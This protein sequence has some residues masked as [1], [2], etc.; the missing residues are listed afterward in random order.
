MLNERKLIISN[1]CRILSSMQLCSPP[2]TE[3]LLEEC[4]ADLFRSSLFLCL[5]CRELTGMD[6][7][8]RAPSNFG[9]FNVPPPGHPQPPRSYFSGRGAP[10]PRLPAPMSGSGSAQ[11][12]LPPQDEEVWKLIDQTV[13]YIAK[14]G[15][16]SEEETRRINYGDPRFQFLFGNEHT[17]YYRFRL[18]NAVRN[19]HGPA[20]FN[21][22]PSFTPRSPPP[23][24]RLIPP[25]LFSVEAGKAQIEKLRKHVADSHANLLAQYNS[26]QTNREEKINAAVKKAERD[27]TYAVI[28]KV[29]LDIEPLNQLLNKFEDACSKDIIQSCKTWIFENCDSDQLREV[30]LSFLLFRVKE[31]EATDTFKLHI[32]YLINDWAIFAQRKRLDNIRQCLSRY[33]SQMYAF[34]ALNKDEKPSSLTDKLEKLLAV[35]DK[36]KTFDDNTLKQVKNPSQVKANYKL[37]LYSEIQKA[38]REVTARVYAEYGTYEQQ[39]NEFQKH[40][41]A[42]IAALEKQIADF[43]ANGPAPGSNN[44]DAA[45]AVN[46][47]GE[48][49]RRTRFDQKTV[50]PPGGTA[51]SRWNAMTPQPTSG[52]FNRLPVATEMT[53]GFFNKPP[54]LSVRP[55]VP[56]AAPMPLKD[57]ILPHS[58]NHSPGPASSGFSNGLGSAHQRDENVQAKRKKYYYECGAGDMLPAVPDD[59]LL[60]NALD[61]DVLYD[62][63]GMPP[64]AEILRELDRFYD[65]HI[66]PDNPRDADG[67]EKRGLQEYYAMKE[68][69]RQKLLGELENKGQDIEDAVTNKFIMERDN[70]EQAERER[71]E[72]RKAR[73]LERYMV[74]SSSQSP[75]SVHEDGDFQSPSRNNKRSCNS[76]PKRHSRTRS[77]SPCER[78][79][80]GGGHGASFF[81]NATNGSSTD[82]TNV[83]ARMMARMGWNGRGI[84]SPGRG[85]AETARASEERMNAGS[86]RAHRSSGY[87]GF[88][89]QTSNNHSHRH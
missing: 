75:V 32:L 42:Q 58:H 71:V 57:V 36:N 16:E 40:A 19:L 37:T 73:E 35:W 64:P 56:Q 43:E 17:E 59:A 67:W 69:Y 76:S 47:T 87:D 61:P 74:A 83:G 8:Y 82:D 63:H 51:N 2:F 1:V 24:P 68:E 10:P 18:M 39:H 15:P 84:G 22:R 53:G 25:P 30:V 60:Y 23:A 55:P 6:Q 14:H 49:T 78:P 70:P 65:S 77:P 81:N 89:K 33:V 29:N 48:V 41:L 54:P 85:A 7:R 66:S 38:D 13:N 27:R 44:Q 86:P 12:P 26:M 21:Q 31:D 9:A 52:F 11:P 50:E 88:R 28:Q 72:A 45:N 80:F 4:I 20:P 34:A 79:S 62:A 46:S 5:P 3:S